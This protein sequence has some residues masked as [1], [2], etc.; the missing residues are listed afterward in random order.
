MNLTRKLEKLETLVD[1]LL[2]EQNGLRAHLENMRDH[3]QSS[4]KAGEANVSGKMMDELERLRSRLADSEATNQQLVR[5]RNGVR[6][7]LTQIRNRLDQVEA[8]LLEK[9]SAS[10]GTKG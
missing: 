4:D 6:E 1:A 10:S 3:S 5:E 9:R 2:E 7:R 8:Q